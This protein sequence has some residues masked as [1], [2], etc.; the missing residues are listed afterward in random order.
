MQ[1]EVFISR[2]DEFTIIFKNDENNIVINLRV[3]DNRIIGYNYKVQKNFENYE[4]R[5]DYFVRVYSKFRKDL[6]NSAKSQR[7]VTL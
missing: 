4:S 2:I 5:S 3:P 1:Y 7:S 6:S